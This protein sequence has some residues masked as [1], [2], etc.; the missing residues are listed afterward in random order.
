MRRV[1]GP[2]EGPT[3]TCSLEYPAR[4]ARLSTAGMTCSDIVSAIR[5][6]CEIDFDTYTVRGLN[7]CS[8]SAAHTSWWD[9]SSWSRIS[10]VDRRAQ[11]TD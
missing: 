9:E 6:V 5:F 1:N 4:V 11:S 8:V 3:A 10:F 2:I 7:G